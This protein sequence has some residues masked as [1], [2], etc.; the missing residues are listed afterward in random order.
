MQKFSKHTVV[1]ALSTGFAT[2]FLLVM[3]ANSAF[4][5][6]ET[7]QINGKVTDPNGA[8]V[9]GAT[10]TV[11]SVSTGAERNATADNDGVYTVTSLQP[12]LYDVTAKGGSFAAAT[13]RVEVITGGRVTV[14]N[15]LGIPQ[16]AGEVTVVGMGGVEVNTTSGQL[17]DVISGTQVRE[18]PTLT[19]NPY[20]LVGISGNAS[21]TD[22]SGRGAGGFSIN[23][24][25]SA[26][27]NILLDGAENV[28]NF[29]AAVG[30]SVP[31][32]SV[33]EFRVVTS[34]FSAEYGRAS[35][36]IVNVT[37]RAGG[38]EFHG[39]LYEF[40]RVSRL[41]SNGFD[42]NAQGL[43][44]GVFARNQFG[45]A[46]GGPVILPRFGEG[47]PSTSNLKNKLFFFNSTEWVRVRSSA[48]VINLVP[49][50]QL[51]AA[52]NANT[53]AFFAANSLQF[54]VN[55]R[56]FTVGEV[57]SSLGLTSGAFASLPGSTPAFGQVLYSV[58]ASVGAGDPQNSYQTVIRADWVPTSNTQIYGRIAIEKQKFFEGSVS[59]SPYQG[60]NT[61]FNAFNQN[62]LISLTHSFSPNFVSQTKLVFNRL[63]SNQPLGEK[64]PSPTLFLRGNT[65]TRLFGNLV[66][67]P[68]YLPFAPGSGIP[69]GGP[70]NVGQVY[71]DMNWVKGSH[72]FR[73][74][75]TYIYMQDNRTFGAYQNSVESLSQA[76][77][78]TGLN[79]FVSG[80]LRRFQ[81]AVDPQGNFFPGSR[82]TL[83]ISF[84]SFTRN[85]LYNEFALY[86]QDSWRVTPRFTANLGLRYEYY[87]VQHNKDPKL[88]SN[89]YAGSGSTPQE[90][91]RNGRIFRSKDSPVGA[92]WNRDLNNFAPRLSFAW[93]INGD[94]KTS[95]RGG[96]GLAYERNFGN[97]TFNVIQNAPAYAVVTIDAG[98][99][100]FSTIPITPSNFGPLSASSGTAALPGIFN[101]RH[102]DQNIRNAYAHSWSAS[103]E[104]EIANRTVASVEWSGSAGRKLY[105]LTND[106]RRGAGFIFF[107]D[108]DPFSRL[109]N[110]FYPL[111]TRGNKG[112]SNYNA[113]IASLD[114]NNIREMGLGF[115]ARYTYS[116]AKDNLS[117]TFSESS[118]NFNLGLLDPFDPNLDYGYAD[119]D[120]R[121]RFSGSFNWQIPY[122]KH[123]HGAAKEI[124]DGWV[125]TGLVNLRSGSPFSVFD[126]T[127]AFFEVC[128]RAE[129]NGALKFKGSGTGP[130]VPGESNRFRFID[131]SGLNPGV[132][133]SA[134]GT[135][136][137]GPFPT[138]MTR[139]NAFRGPGFWNADVAVFKNFKF[140]ENRSLQLRSE[141]YNIF[142]HPNLFVVGGDA[143][144]SSFD[145]VAARKLGRRFI[146]FALKF[147]F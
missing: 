109:N 26:S 116:V 60:Y 86:F 146:Q 19:R 92:L 135:S 5:Q 119:F 123:Y 75:G 4:G 63:N 8:V 41:A 84:P 95:L 115:T 49:T 74:G 125:V 131:L 9:P 28:D 23:G 80:T 72:Q 58:P 55:G 90:Q 50:P 98:A 147:N 34:T 104:R 66:A 44:K 22:P 39:S 93:D 87:G 11:K 107:G 21:S 62:H 43:P 64:P 17:S 132:Y 121:H 13:Q 56:I 78:S 112:R 69:F 16:V 37:T 88:E 124:L 15:K 137:F 110:Q 136:E 33:Q 105:D 47:G 99:P 27:T 1:K 126:C 140:G 81:V 114:S 2:L 68:G 24:Q 53:Q 52:S 38:N 35:G 139:R 145:Y 57:A 102:V 82:V 122:A 118:N 40:N 130:A 79:N 106:N 70:Q 111:N 65:A 30:Q 134:N 113:L 10:V 71:E 18:L 142:N 127:N 120:V 54:P 3:V 12:G 108:A 25:R 51:I 97:V 42:N 103:F 94:G 14:E 83:P 31:L 96:Y 48:S 76:A 20:D 29:V 144:I 100:G 117:S 59:S 141:F 61:G 73:F 32:D 6:A 77:I 67:L 36:G 89:F 45:Y 85:N 128:M 143:D 133:V 91:I 7:G 101:V 46:I 129:A 138:D